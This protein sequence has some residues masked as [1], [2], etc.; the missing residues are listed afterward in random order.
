MRH[1][2]LSTFFPLSTSPLQCRL[3][4]PL[5]S[6]HHVFFL[7]Y[8]L[9]AQVSRSKKGSLTSRNFLLSLHDPE[10]HPLLTPLD[11]EQHPPLDPSYPDNHLSPP[12]STHSSGRRSGEFFAAIFALLNIV[13]RRSLQTMTFHYRVVKKLAAT[14]AKMVIISNSSRRAVVTGDKL[15]SLSTRLSSLGILITSGELTHQFIVSRQYERV[16]VFSKIPLPNYRPDL[17]DR[18]PLREVSIPFDL[19]REVDNLLGDHLQRKRSTKGVLP[20]PTFS[21]SSSSDS[22]I[23]NESRSAF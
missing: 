10:H 9:L 21:R 3:S 1:L 8:V 13:C 2:P 22:F 11:P 19:Q 5:F 6:A 17:D 12:L 7:C 23:A 15:K 4:F 20:G 16:V 14:W 18:K